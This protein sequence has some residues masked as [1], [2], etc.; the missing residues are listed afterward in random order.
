MSREKYITLIA[1][2][3]IPSPGRD[4]FTQFDPNC[5]R[6]FL[7]DFFEVVVKSP[8]EIDHRRSEIPIC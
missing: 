3:I 2:A 7:P 1:L 5:N 8:N 6:D 4:D